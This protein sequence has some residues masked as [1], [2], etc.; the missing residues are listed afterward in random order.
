MRKKSR[1][2]IIIGIVLILFLIGTTAFYQKYIY[3]KMIDPKIVTE[4]LSRDYTLEKV[5]NPEN[6][7]LYM[8]EA[9]KKNDLDM[10]L[11]G[12]PI[13]EMGLYANVTE[14]LEPTDVFS[15][16]TVLAPSGTYTDYFPLTSA[17]LTSAFAKEFE[18][19]EK[20]TADLGELSVE[21]IDFAKPQEQLESKEQLEFQELCGK[22]Q[23]S[24]ATEMSVLLKSGSQ[25]YLMGFSLL[26]YDGYWWVCSLTSE[27]CGTTEDKAIREITLEEYENLT[28]KKAAADVEKLLEESINE[29]VRKEKK[30]IKKEEKELICSGEALL[31]ANYYV[32]NP[33]YGKSPED[34]IGEFTKHIQK[35]DLQMV[36]CYGR[37]DDDREKL[38][39]SS[40]ILANQ[41]DFAAQVKNFYFNLLRGAD[42]A[43]G[44]TLNELGES[45]GTVVAKLNPDNM[46]FIQLWGG[47]QDS[48][49]ENIYIASY[50][51][52]QEN[53]KVKFALKKSIKGWQIEEILQVKKNKEK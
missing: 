47:E 8:A 31:P 13:D 9:L 20:Q 5:M 21:R 35:R 43:E 26:S 39:T 18:T 48:G 11:R 41:S 25:K 34:L 46:F 19:V 27:L 50:E 29:T 24:A 4:E 23:A 49:N 6:M 12:F 44:K 52:A 2:T 30:E 28:D 38:H 7:A 45:A 10:G 14:M 1:Y 40:D 51:Y 16:T 17:E 15:Y 22:W 42:G 53:Y 32:V 36:L 37:M 33:T 3:Y